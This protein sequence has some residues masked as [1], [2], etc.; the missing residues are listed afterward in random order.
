[1][2]INIT[3][4]NVYVN[5]YEGYVALCMENELIRYKTEVNNVPFFLLLGKG[6]RI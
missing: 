3:H 6:S 1:M 2:L 5:K 4:V